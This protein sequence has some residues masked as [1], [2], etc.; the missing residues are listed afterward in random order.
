VRERLHARHQ[1][2]DGGDP[3]MKTCRERRPVRHA[4]RV[5]YNREY[6]SEQLTADA[7][8]LAGSPITPHTEAIMVANRMRNCATKCQR[9]CTATAAFPVSYVVCMRRLSY[10]GTLAHQGFA[11]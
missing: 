10:R 2:S 11:C 7:G 3:H 8:S 1:R 9:S 4:I 6:L 5:S